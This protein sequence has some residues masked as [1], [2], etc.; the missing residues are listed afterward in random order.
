M[1]PHAA[2]TRATIVLMLVAAAIRQDRHGELAD[3]H[4]RL[5]FGSHV[6]IEVPCRSSLGL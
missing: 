2:N 5:S 3:G 4:N 6:E 1:M